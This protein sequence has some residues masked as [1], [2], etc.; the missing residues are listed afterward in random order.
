MM[1]PEEDNFAAADEDIACSNGSGASTIRR[2]KRK[3]SSSSLL[4]T[5]VK[6]M[7]VSVR[8]R[9]APYYI[10]IFIYCLIVL[11]LTS[12]RFSN[13]SHQASASSRNM[14][15]ATESPHGSS[16]TI[17]QSLTFK[18]PSRLLFSY[19][20]GG[21]SRAIPPPT[22]DLYNSP[23]PYFAHLDFDSLKFLPESKFYRYIHP[24][25]YFWHEEERKQQLG[26]IDHA[27]LETEY[28][29]FL[30]LD[31]PQPECHRLEWADSMHPTCNHFHEFV[32]LDRDPARDLLQ[33][34]QRRYLAHGF[35]RDAW[36]LEPAANASRYEPSASRSVVLKSLRI[37]RD[38]SI[39][40]A[41]SINKEALI[42]ERMS[43]SPR[44]MN[45]YGHCYTSMLVEHGYEISQRMVQGVEY[46]GRGRISQQE[47]DEE[48]KDGVKPKNNFTVEE[49]L[50]IA[51]AMAEG[52]AELHGR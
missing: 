27:H 19:S 21:Q 41:V 13:F 40:T 37:E 9:L 31:Y 52:I 3:R 45:L 25:E 11:K 44:I 50:E 1:D 35:F 18:A 16:T 32:V 22:D 14:R 28:E 17:H 10:C 8:N 20:L 42:M 47:L 15:L 43:A 12:N 30:D 33:P 51:L 5:K 4:G 36:L 38:F 49:K 39:D 48:E 7:V 6:D 23:L 29:P 46:N 26:D 24:D 34:L 2:L